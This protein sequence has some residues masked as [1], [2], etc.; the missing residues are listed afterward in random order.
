[1][2][3]RAAPG[4]GLPGWRLH[5]EWTGRTTMKRLPGLYRN[6]RSYIRDGDGDDDADSVLCGQG[7]RHY[8]PRHYTRVRVPRPHQLH[9]VRLKISS[10]RLNFPSPDWM[11]KALDSVGGQ[12]ANN[13]G[14]EKKRREK[15]SPPASRWS[16]DS[17]W[18]ANISSRGRPVGQPADWAASGGWGR[19]PLFVC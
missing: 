1:M 15:K 8:L 16:G 2:T 9:S 11:R 10:N 7:Q 12:D 5:S 18:A 14:K 6:G 19:V 3:K 4:S 17:S 13:W